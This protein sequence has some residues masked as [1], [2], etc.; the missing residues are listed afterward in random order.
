MSETSRFLSVG[1]DRDVQAVYEYASDPR[2]LPE[3]APGLGSSITA[4]GDSWMVQTPD[5]PVMVRF[6][7]PNEFGV[8]DH[9]VTQPD[10]HTV[11][12]IPL[13]VTAG[14]D[15]SSEVVFTVRKLPGMTDT[16][17]GRD[18][19]AVQADLDRL[20]AILERD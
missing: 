4:A 7:P 20:R 9:W 6:A 15:S 3:W 11:V 16:E 12:Y 2:H 5:G 14:G 19:A 18:C 13:R 17:F 10:G 1:I 8:L